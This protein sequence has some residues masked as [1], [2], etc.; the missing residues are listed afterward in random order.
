MILTLVQQ[1]E[2]FDSKLFQGKHV[3]LLFRRIAIESFDVFVRGSS[4]FTQNEFKS[5]E[6]LDCKRAIYQYPNTINTF[7]WQICCLS[8]KRFS[9][10]FFFFFF[11]IRNVKRKWKIRCSIHFLAQ[12]KEPLNKQNSLTRY[13]STYLRSLKGFLVITTTT[14][15]ARFY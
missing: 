4:I 10:F 14:Q 15:G 1:D 6:K 3:K 7:Q 12:Q 9:I 2:S 8:S 5:I 13:Y 11:E